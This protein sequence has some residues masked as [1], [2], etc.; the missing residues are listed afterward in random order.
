MPLHLTINV[1]IKLVMQEEMIASGGM[2]DY[3][4]TLCGIIGGIITVLG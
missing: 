4:T 2:V 1:Q 3:I